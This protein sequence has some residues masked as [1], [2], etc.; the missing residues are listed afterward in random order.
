MWRAGQSWCWWMYHSWARVAIYQQLKM[1]LQRWATGNAKREIQNAVSSCQRKGTI[2]HG[3]NKYICSLYVC[4]L[5]NPWL[6][7]AVQNLF[8]IS[9]FFFF[10][11]TFEINRD[12]GG[13][14]FDFLVHV[15]NRRKV[16]KKISNTKI[17]SDILFFFRPFFFYFIFLV[18]VLSSSFC[19]FHLKIFVLLWEANASRLETSRRQSFGHNDVVWARM[20]PKTTTSRGYKEWLCWPGRCIQSLVPHSK[21]TKFTTPLYSTQL[22]P[23][24][25]LSHTTRRYELL[26]SGK[27][28]SKNRIGNINC[29]TDDHQ[30]KG[31]FWILNRI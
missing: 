1:Q 15:A 10:G 5:G 2:P 26:L 8:R 3:Q 24:T 28:W 27:C 29:W 9:S 31:H 19:V 4:G 18:L 22:S 30:R 16:P 13:G 23:Q 6:S 25:T 12:G 20:Y 14:K 7:W 17:V 11:F 21:A